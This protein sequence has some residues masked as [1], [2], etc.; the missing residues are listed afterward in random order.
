MVL[1]LRRSSIRQAPPS[2]VAC[3]VCDEIA[4]CVAE[5]VAIGGFICEE[6]IGYA[7]SAEMLIMSTWRWGKVRHPEPNEFS[8]WENH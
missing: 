4:M 3:Y 5:D 2:E 7:L 6:C 8:D 1:T